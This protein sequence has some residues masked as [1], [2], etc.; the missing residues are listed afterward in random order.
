MKSLPTLVLAMIV[1]ITTATAQKKTAPDWTDIQQAEKL[2]NK[3]PRKI[4]VDIYTSWCGWCKK[5]DS[6]GFAESHIREYLNRKFYPVKLDA[7]FKDTLVFNGQTYINTSPKSVRPTHQ[8]AATLLRGQLVYPSL[9]I[10]DEKLG[11]ITV[12]KG[13]KKPSELEA[14]LHFYGDDAYQKQSYEQFRQE[15]RGK[16]VDPEE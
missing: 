16:A 13:Y 1:C 12:I 11:V 14:L 2:C 15:F 6:V 9:V 5:Y 7:E 8:L 3:A 4:F 10:L